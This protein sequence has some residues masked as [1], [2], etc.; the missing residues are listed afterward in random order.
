LPLGLRKMI[1]RRRDSLYLMFLGAIAFLL[2]GVALQ[3]AT[4]EP[5]GD[6][7]GIYYEAGCALHHCDPYNPRQMEAFYAAQGGKAPTQAADR[8]FFINVTVGV[9]LPTTLICTLPL[10]MMPWSAAQISWTVIN[11][12]VFVLASFLV[13]DIAAEFAPLLSAASICVCFATSELFLVLGNPA[14]IVISSCA[15]AVWCGLRQRF[16]PLAVACLALALVIKPHDSGLVWLYFLASKGHLRSLARRALLV[17]VAS[18]VASVV[19]ISSLAP[20]WLGELRSNLLSLS[21]PGGLN[22]PGPSSMAGHGIGMIVSLQAAFSEFVDNPRF[23]DAAAYGVFGVLL[24]I[25]LITT[26]RARREHA[27]NLLGLAPATALTLLP[28]Y[29]RIYDAKLILLA[30]PACSI[31]WKRGGPQAWGASLITLTGFVVTGAI[32]WAI[33]FPLLARLLPHGGNF[34]RW[35]LIALQ[36]C[37]VPAVLLAFSVFYLFFFVKAAGHAEPTESPKPAAVVTLN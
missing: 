29:H 9:N 34:A 31:L 28:I 21:Q 7:K 19:W 27:L 32:P 16:G 36:S 22:D 20:H 18:G 12:A 1:D 6:F 35:V 14:C 25:W 15:V 5:L 24:A 10:A 4:R 11:A 3:G 30:V 23:Y 13:W 37:V 17:A 26:R 8:E 33:S 2:I